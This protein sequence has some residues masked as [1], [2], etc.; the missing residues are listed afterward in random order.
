MH[1][2]ESTCI[3]SSHALENCLCIKHARRTC[4]GRM[5]LES[6]VSI[7]PTSHS[8]STAHK[9]RTLNDTLGC[10]LHHTH[11]AGAQAAGNKMQNL[12]LEQNKPQGAQKLA[13]AVLKSAASELM[14]GRYPGGE[15]A[16]HKPAS[17]GAPAAQASRPSRPPPNAAYS[18]P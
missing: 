12:M 3:I 4:S 2:H 17:E 15:G 18:F 14:M 1:T 6:S 13:S 11:M 5:K 10:A 8:A 7:A 16:H 9:A